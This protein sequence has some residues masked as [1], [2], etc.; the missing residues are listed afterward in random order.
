MTSTDALWLRIVQA[1]RDCPND[2]KGWHHNHPECSKC[3]G[4]GRVAALPGL[5]E[6]HQRLSHPEVVGTLG[7]LEMDNVLY[8]SCTDVGCPGYQ[9]VP[10]SLE[11][12]MGA[13]QRV[14]PARHR[15]ETFTDSSVGFGARLGEDGFVGYV[16]YDKWSPLVALITVTECYLENL[17][18]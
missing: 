13:L 2:H 15:A 5:R 10:P 11:L 6:P 12:L 17:H 3:H 8:R 16:A 14:L 18:A 4:T 9:P 7:L 1:E